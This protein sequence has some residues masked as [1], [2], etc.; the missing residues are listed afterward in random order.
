MLFLIISRL[1]CLASKSGYP[2]KRPS[3]QPVSDEYDL[4]IIGGGSGGLALSKE[5]S[6]LG[7]KVALLDFV[8]QTP[9]GSQWGLGGTCVNVG[10]EAKRHGNGARVGMGEYQQ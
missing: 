7:Q 4:I 8:E 10:Q 9:H 6:A 3:A 5:A 1:P 2:L